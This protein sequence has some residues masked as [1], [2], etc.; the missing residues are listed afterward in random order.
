MT[1]YENPF[2]I[3]VGKGENAG[4]SAFSPFPTVFSILPKTIFK[5]SIT[6]TYIMSSANAFNRDQYNLLSVIRVKR[7][8][9]LSNDKI[10]DQ[11]TVKAFA[12][13]KLKVIQM[14]KFVLDKTENIVEKEENAGYQNFLLFLQCFQKAFSIRSLKVEIVLYRV[15]SLKFI[16]IY[17]DP[18]G[19]TF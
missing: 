7:V 6:C 10:L 18:E 2:E 3:I 1:L 19:N 13:D 9:P 14:A 16:K 15:N 8:N 12:D 5:F 11:S 4:K 17:D